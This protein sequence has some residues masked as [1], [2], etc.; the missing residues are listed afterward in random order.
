MSFWLLAAC[1]D[2]HNRIHGADGGKP[3]MSEDR[4]RELLAGMT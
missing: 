2:G 1:V 3:G 4:Y